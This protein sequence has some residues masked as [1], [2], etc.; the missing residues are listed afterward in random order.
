MTSTDWSDGHYD[1]ALVEAMRRTAAIR[2]R[3]Y[4][5]TDCDVMGRSPEED[6]ENPVCW[7][8]GKLVAFLG[9]SIWPGLGAASYHHY[10]PNDEDDPFAPAL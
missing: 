2:G 9:H 6:G 10:E 8:C 5:C 4:W 3:S 1:V 7:F